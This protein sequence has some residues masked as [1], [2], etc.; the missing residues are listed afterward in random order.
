MFILSIL[1]LN[2]TFLI[3]GEL[4]VIKLLSMISYSIIIQ[5]EHFKPLIQ[6][7]DWLLQV[8]VQNLCSKV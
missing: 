2:K 3:L 7:S 6:C 1:I 5:S 8:R 4:M